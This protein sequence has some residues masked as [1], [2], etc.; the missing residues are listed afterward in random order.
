MSKP[1]TNSSNRQISKLDF[2]A[3]AQTPELE[4]YLAAS[5]PKQEARAVENLS[6]QGIKAFC[7]TIKV[8]KLVRGNKKIIDEALFT[9]YLFVQISQ[10]NP[11]WQ[12]VRSTRG[13]RDWVKFT[14]EV[15]KVPSDLV[16]ELIDLE[17]RVESKLVVSRFNQGDPIRVLSGPF[18]G[19]TGV[20]EKDDGEKRSMILLEFMGKLNLI[21]IP[22]EQI[23][24]NN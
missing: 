6:N 4:W 20:F 22:N 1:L 23:I 12:K 18:S 19:L 11:L 16:T 9:G 7:P 8:E 24:T 21:K 15:A 5:K 13:V 10:V 17:S 14:G 3:S 2:A